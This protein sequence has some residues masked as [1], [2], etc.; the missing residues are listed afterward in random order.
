MDVATFHCTPAILD[1][2]R[3]VKIMP[4]LIPP[5]CTSFLQPLDTAINKV[6]KQWLREAA[7][8]YITEREERLG[9][10]EKWSISDKRIMTTWIVATAAKRL[11]EER[12]EMTQQAFIQCSITIRPDST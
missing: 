2:L 7:D 12:Q 8:D 4:A 5:S 3:S 10:F 6:F 11:Y 1:Q 9:A